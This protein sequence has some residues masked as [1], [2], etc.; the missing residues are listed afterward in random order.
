MSEVNGRLWTLEGAR[1]FLK[2][3]I[4]MRIIATE[5]RKMSYAYKINTIYDMIKD[6]AEQGDYSICVEILNEKIIKQL[7]EDGYNVSEMNYNDKY[8]ITWW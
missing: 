5:A 6:A 8:R 1:E 4:D 3:R 7:K 2:G